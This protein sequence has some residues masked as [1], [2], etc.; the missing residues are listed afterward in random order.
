[1]A[2]RAEQEHDNLR[3]A[4][5]WAIDGGESETA[6][7]MSGPIWRFWYARGHLEEARR[8]LESA[9]D[10]RSSGRPTTARARAL[11]ALG[12]IAYWQGDLDTALR[13]YEEALDIH[14][15]LGDR[16][17]IVGALL[18]VGETRAVKGDTASGIA[19]M[20]ESLALALE[21]GDRRGEAWALWGL[22]AARLIASDLDNSREYLQESLRI[23]QEVG[24]DTWGWANALGGLRGLTAL[25]SDPNDAR[26]L[27]LETFALYGEQVNAVIITGHLRFL[28]GVANQLGQHERAARLAGA[29][30]AWRGKIGGRVPNAF[31]PYEDPGQAAARQLSDEVFKRAWAEGQ[32]MSLE[33][34]LAHATEET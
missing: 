19:L 29:E 2:R 13:S 25:Q 10:L 4:L 9:L 33:E 31:F 18:N 27:I 17:A 28:S 1:L 14:R 5:A 16:L 26:K 32:A 7:R 15:D 34:A 30:A 23:F 11:T 8:W 12:G 3:A 22:G 21:L 20:D 6:L 24:Y